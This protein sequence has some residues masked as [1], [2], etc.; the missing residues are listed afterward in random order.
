[1]RNVFTLFKIICS[2]TTKPTTPNDANFARDELRNF[3]T[4]FGEEVHDLIDTELRNDAK[5][6]AN[7]GNFKQISE[8]VCQKFCETHCKILIP[9]AVSDTSACPLRVLT[10]L[11]VDEQGRASHQKD[12][13]H[14]DR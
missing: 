2:Y 3:P 5:F 6:V 8:T 1:M 13:K 11:G 10:S 9:L 12:Q 7:F 14:T 4:K